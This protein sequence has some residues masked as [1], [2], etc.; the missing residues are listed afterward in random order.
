MITYWKCKDGFSEI[1]QWK[2]GC[3]IKVNDPTDDD[4]SVLKE[5]FDVPLDFTHDAQDIEER[6]RVDHDEGWMLVFL[7][8][9]AKAID[10]DGDTVFSTAPMAILIRDDVFIS[11]NYYD[12]EVDVAAARA[13]SLLEPIIIC[14]LAVFVVFVLLAVYMPMFSMYGSIGA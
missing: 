1:N 7:R 5:R 11:V 14:V 12:N 3:W 2:S 10:Q 8:L 9:P 6:P 4:L 13:V